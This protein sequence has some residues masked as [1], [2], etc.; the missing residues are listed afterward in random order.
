MRRIGRVETDRLGSIVSGDSL[1]GRVRVLDP[2]F[3][4]GNK[5]GLG[6]RL[7]GGRQARMGPRPGRHTEEIGGLGRVRH[8][9][10]RSH[11]EYGYSANR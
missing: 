5:D 8:G 10:R 1:E 9:W 3:S 6:G 7:D 4:I 2:A 11:P